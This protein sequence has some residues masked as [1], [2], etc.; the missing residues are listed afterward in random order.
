[1]E[2]ISKLLDARAAAGSSAALPSDV[3]HRARPVVDHRVEVAVRG[4]VAQAD[5]HGGVTLIM[6]FNSKF[7]KALWGSDLSYWIR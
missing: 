3:L 6:L 1:M 7:V 5:Q 4:R 2:A